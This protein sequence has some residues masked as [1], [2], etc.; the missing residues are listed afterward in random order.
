VRANRKN[1]VREYPE[2]RGAMLH[3]DR[4]SQYTSGRYHKI[5]V[6]HGLI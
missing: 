6:K 5:I 1:T 2:L 3:S 4:R